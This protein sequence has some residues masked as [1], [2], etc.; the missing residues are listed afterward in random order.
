MTYSMAKL[1]GQVQHGGMEDDFGLPDR[2]LGEHAEWFYPAVGRIACICALLETKAQA[3]AEILARLDQGSLT[4]KP[5][6]VMGE[7]GTSAAQMVDSA[8][9]SANATPISPLVAEFYKNVEEIM[10]RRHAVIHAVWPAQLEEKQLGYRPDRASA[11]GK[12][13]VS[14]DNTRAGMVDLIRT[15]VAMVDEGSRLISPVSFAVSQALLAGYRGTTAA[16]A[17][18]AADRAAQAGKAAQ[19]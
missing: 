17:M 18:K 7:T 3:L 8:Y 16:A 14:S 2:M 5:I 19:P 15:A 9:Q 4:R 13:L 1:V 11:H 12:V 6:S 10:E